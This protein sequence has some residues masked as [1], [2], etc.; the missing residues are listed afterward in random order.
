MDKSEDESWEMSGDVNA[1]QAW[2]GKLEEKVV[3]WKENL[4]L[5]LSNFNKMEK[6]AY[7]KYKLFKHD[8]YGKIVIF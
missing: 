7:F 6:D 8:V 2:E 5:S 1:L 3:N 4:I